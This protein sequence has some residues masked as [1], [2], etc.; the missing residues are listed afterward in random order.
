MLMGESC[1]Q[2]MKS[3]LM[4]QPLSAEEWMSTIDNPS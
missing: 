2:E 3:H 1:V 4:C